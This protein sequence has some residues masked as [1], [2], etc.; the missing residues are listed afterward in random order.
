VQRH[1]EGL[2]QRAARRR[3]PLRDR[4][5]GAARSAPHAEPRREAA[6]GPAVADVVVR[7]GRVDHHGLPRLEAA[8]AHSH[9]LDHAAELVAERH[10]LLRRAGD[11]AERHVAE[12]GAADPAGQDAH[13]RVLG[14][15]L[16]H[17]DL[18][19]AEVAR[20]VDPRRLHPRLRRRGR[21]TLLHVAEVA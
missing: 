13:E 14:A 21:G 2:D 3:H 19:D 1:G 16:G 17:R 4:V 7:R 20:T 10:R 11:A 6:L 12:V 9:P 5:D 8:H 18:V 15:G